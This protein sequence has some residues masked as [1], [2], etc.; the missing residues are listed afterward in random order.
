MPAWAF[1]FPLK[2]CGWSLVKLAANIP[3]RLAALGLL[4]IAG[5]GVNPVAML[6]ITGTSPQ[7]VTVDG[8]RAVAGEVLVKYRRSLKSN[9]RAQLDQQTPTGMTRSA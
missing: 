7:I 9:E 3:V 1:D 2:R 8:R 5:L 6:G 4:A